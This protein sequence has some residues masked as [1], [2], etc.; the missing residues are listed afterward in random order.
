MS[1]G[2]LG[3][4]C[5]VVLV[6]LGGIVW[7]K[8]AGV[9]V[10]VST[11][12]EL[13]SAISEASDGKGM[14]KQ[15]LVVRFSP[16]CEPMTLGKSDLWNAASEC[17]LDCGGRRISLDARECPAGTV[18][19]GDETEGEGPVSPVSIKGCGKGSSF[20]NLTVV[21]AGRLDF[22]SVEDTLV[23]DCDFVRCVASNEGRSDAGG[24][25]RGCGS[26]EGCGFA[27][28]AARL[29]GALSDCAVVEECTFLD[30]RAEDGGGAIAGASDV[31]R[32]EFRRCGAGSDASG[33]GG[34]ILGGRD[35]V[36]CLFVDCSA[37]QGGAVM[38]VGQDNGLHAKIVHCTFVRCAGEADGAAV[39]EASDGP[40]VFMLNSLFY[41]CDRWQDGADES[42]KYNCHRLV[43]T[44]FFADCAKGDYRPNPGL[45][46]PWED[47][48]GLRFGDCGAEVGL[49][50][51][52]DLDGYGYDMS[53]PWPICPGC[54]RFRVKRESDDT[55]AVEPSGDKKYQVLGSR[56]HARPGHWRKPAKKRSGAMVGGRRPQRTSPEK[57]K[58]RNAG[59]LLDLSVLPCEV[60]QA[61][62][63]HEGNDILDFVNSWYVKHHDIL[64]MFER[65]DSLEMPQFGVT[66]GYGC[67]GKLTPYAEDEEL[68]SLNRRYGFRA[69]WFY[70]GFPKKGDRFYDDY[71][72]RLENW[73]SGTNAYACCA[74]SAVERIP[75]L[76]AQGPGEDRLPLV[77]YIAGNGEQGTD[78]KKMFRQPGVFD[79]VRNPAFAERHPCH[80]L[81][82][83]PPEFAHRGGLM[84]HPHSY[85]LCLDGVNGRAPSGGLDLVRMYADLIFDLQRELES[86]G[87][88]G[89]DSRA[90][91]LV[92]LG[93]GADAAISMMHEFPGRF[94]GV[95]AAWATAPF[96]PPTTNRYRPGRWLFSLPD[97]HRQI[98]TFRSMASAMKQLGADVRLG[99]YPAGDNWWNRSWSS[100]EFGVWIA[101]CFEKGPLYGEKLVVAE[102]ERRTDLLLARTGPH[103]ATYFGV[104]GRRPDGLPKE[105]ADRRIS[106]LKGIRC[107]F[108]DGKA[109]EVPPEAFAHAPD[110][111]SVFFEDYLVV[112]PDKAAADPRYVGSSKCDVTNV[113]ARAFADS[114]K[115]NLVMFNSP[116]RLRIA[117]SAFDGCVS[118]LYGGTVGIPVSTNNGM[119]VDMKALNLPVDGLFDNHLFIVGGRDRKHRHVDGEF[120]WEE[121][122]EGARV[123]MYLGESRDVFVPGR[124]AGL[125]V[126]SVGPDL[127]HRSGGFEYGVLALPA[128]VKGMSFRPNG[129]KV[130]R[131]FAA[132]K[133]AP[134]A[135]MVLDAD[136][137]LYGTTP[138]ART[139]KLLDWPSWT[140][141]EV[142]VPKGTDPHAFFAGKR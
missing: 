118:P 18:V 89:I 25:I 85:S 139:G 2:S 127:L 59:P 30:C 33:C 117:S 70:R 120:L 74:N 35:I 100:P 27:R 9:R 34:A 130:R 10:T 52:R 79:A 22:D 82:V 48:C 128:S 56:R 137:V 113:A 40:A 132:C 43:R 1:L 92:G 136:S 140:G 91:V 71:C 54:Y 49:F 19:I 131:L 104:A 14:L 77:V 108:I 29:G 11:K 112:E 51:C 39:C 68:T 129:P 46:E 123:L 138:D 75:Y 83:M 109:G 102:P 105:L 110:L 65:I 81:A 32:C 124:L 20:C 119:R 24:A 37:R 63:P 16:E 98:E 8:T 121:D 7:A 41:G 44:D 23:K 3:R 103:E 72:Q 28:C 107:L 134:S 6:I 76:F 15:D 126:V 62:V 115:L 94:A 47:P 57:A 96:Y 13:L 26:V 45:T 38:S 86:R 80:L 67:P 116:W 78:L 84:R 135:E 50:T 21:N 142:V 114:P 90:I 66:P 99:V 111:E 69:G 31:A 61:E 42:N 17:L 106:D 4:H 133:L 101:D 125:P 87:N 141:K 60:S 73:K 64:R 5:L 58:D 55:P 88:A 97:T 122:G 53:S 95:S 93:S 12:E 36:S